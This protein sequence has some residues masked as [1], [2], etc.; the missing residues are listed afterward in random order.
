LQSPIALYSD[1]PV[2]ACDLQLNG[3]NSATELTAV[4]MGSTGSRIPETNI[5]ILF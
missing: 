2:K 3:Y 4:N 5:Y 1:S